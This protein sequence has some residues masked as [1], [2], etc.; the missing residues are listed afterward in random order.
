MIASSLLHKISSGTKWDAK[1]R[2]T[3]FLRFIL[4]V[5]SIN[6]AEIALDF[7]PGMRA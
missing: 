6:I 2:N 1:H 5:R 4:N 7:N 3:G